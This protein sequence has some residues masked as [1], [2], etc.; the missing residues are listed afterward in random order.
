[1]TYDPQIHD[2]L[3]WQD[4][5]NKISEWNDGTEDEFLHN[6]NVYRWGFRNNQNKLIL[7]RIED[8]PA[9]IELSPTNEEIR[10]YKNGELY[11]DNDKPCCIKK[12]GFR[13]WHKRPKGFPM[14]VG[15]DGYRNFSINGFHPKEW[16]TESVIKSIEADREFARFYTRCSLIQYFALSKDIQKILLKADPTL[17]S[18]IRNVDPV[19]KEEYS[20]HYELGE[21]GL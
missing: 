19:L 2:Y 21:I 6:S 16:L 14:E 15:P 9:Y 20:G 4:D 18:I 1:M 17:V 10:W 7:N 11:R 5:W 3:D 8:K 13:Y 12:N